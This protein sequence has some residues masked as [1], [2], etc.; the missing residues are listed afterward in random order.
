MAVYANAQKWLDGELS[1]GRPFIAG[2]DYSMADICALST[3]DFAKWIGLPL[4]EERTH[5]KAWHERVK[6]RPSSRA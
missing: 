4:D 6:A 5:L 1:D 2:K 3:V